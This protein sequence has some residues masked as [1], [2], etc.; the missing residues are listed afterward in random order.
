M[1]ILKL[2][3]G[4]EIVSGDIDEMVFE[5]GVYLY[6]LNNGSC[7][8]GN[9][10]TPYRVLPFRLDFGLKDH[11]SDEDSQIISEFHLY[12]AV[13]EIQDSPE[14]FNP[15]RPSL[16]EL[17]SADEASSFFDK[18]LLSSPCMSEES[19]AKMLEF[20]ERL[21]MY[22]RRYRAGFSLLLVMHTALVIDKQSTWNFIA[23]QFMR[24][25]YEN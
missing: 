13:E 1:D 23:E 21:G 8:I 12:K 3:S 15:I 4:G 14:Q 6:D 11:L 10:K 9:G 18:Y 17:V 22:Q 5:K 24:G 2:N 25:V 19:Q 16:F 20:S 7:K